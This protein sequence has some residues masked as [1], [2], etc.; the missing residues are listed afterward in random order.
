MK[1]KILLLIMAIMF[2]VGINAQRILSPEEAVSTA[3][4]EN[5]DILIARNDADISRINNTMGNAG[6][7]PEI[8][9]NG[10]GSKNNET[11][12]SGSTFS[13]GAELSWT[14]FDGGKMFVT[15]R[16]L[17]ELQTIGELQFRSKVMEVIYNV[18]AAYYDVVRQ[19]QE[20]KY[21]N[22]VIDYNRQRVTIAQTGFN[23]G[24]MDKTELLQAQID[25]NVATE[26]AINQQ[27]IIVK[28]KKALSNILGQSN[29]QEYDVIDS[30]RFTV[31]PVEADVLRNL[32]LSNVGILAMQKQV[33]VEGLALQEVKRTY[34]P[35]LNF[36]GGYYLSQTS[37]SESTLHNNSH[38]L[39]M[40]GT[41]SVPIYNAGETKRKLSVAKMNLLS[42]QYNLNNLKLQ[43][44][45][46]LQNAYADYDNQ[47]RLLRI[48]KDNCK[49]AA[50][51]MEICLKRM[52]LGQTTSLEVHQAQE[53][54]MESR[55]RLLNFQYNLKIAETKIKQ[56]VS[57]L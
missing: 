38:G 22:Q 29:M 55:T 56:L 35:S 7:L 52:E 25:F 26:N 10:S 40:S 54:Y 32:D 9:L 37:T 36:K 5:F 15:K 43:T 45:I 44:G 6:M 47:T 13:A 53:N 23:A 30:V 12:K 34:L 33:D 28:T 57:S 16:K 24:Q 3:L 31:I 50:E 46:D 8:G 51:N 21:I 2:A 19:K 27:N 1:K 39:Q 4:K 17:S 48:E 11:D 14:L 41:L 49:L 42:S 20:L 18:M